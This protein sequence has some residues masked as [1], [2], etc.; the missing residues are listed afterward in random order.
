MLTKHEHRW[1]GLRRSF[2]AAAACLLM[3]AAAPNASAAPLLLPHAVLGAI[4]VTITSHPKAVTDV[5]GAS[6]SWSTTGIVGET[7]CRIDA[8][9]FTYCPGH[10]ARY[11]GLGDGHHTFTIRIRNGYK[12]TAT[13]SFSWLIDTVAPTSPNVIGGSLVWRSPASATVSASGS[14]D[15]LS[16]LAGYHWRSSTDGSAW[17]SVS[18]GATAVIRAQG[19]TYVQFQ[20]V[21]KAGNVSAWQ[22]A[23]NSPTNEVRLDHTPP[24]A[25]TVVGG[26]ALWQ[27]VASETVTGSGSTDARSGVDRYEYRE[28]L[29]GGSSWTAVQAGSSDTVTDE[30]ERLV[31]FRA[32]DAAGNPGPWAP[33]LPGG[34]NTV[35]IDRSGPSSPLVAGGSASWS[36]ATAV[37]V[38]GSG[39]VDAGFGVDHYLHRES[40]DGGV[41]WSSPVTGTSVTIA[42]EGQTLVQF[43]SVDTAGNSSAW[44]PS[45]GSAAGTVRLDRTGPAD[46]TV[47]ITPPGWQSTLAILVFGSGSTDALAG[48]DHYQ[49]RSSADGGSTWSPATDGDTGVVTAEGSTI[50][51]FRAVDGAGNAS[52]W[53]PGAAGVSN[54]V[55]IDRTAPT[56]PT[57]AGGSAS[58][59]ATAS[60]AISASGSTDALGNLDHYEYRRSTDGGI[61]WGVPATGAVDNVTA[62]GETLVQLRAVDAAGNASP[63]VPGS[64]SAG[65][66]RLDRSAPGD[67]VVSGGSLAWQSAASVTVTGSGSSDPGGSGAGS[68]EYR[69]S[70]DN[71][72]SYG[73]AASGASV[74]LN[75]AGNYVVQFRAVDGVGLTSAW[76]PATP[77]FANTA[78]IT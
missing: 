22:P 56:A 78:C 13:A 33:A 57:V 45:P 37:T 46:P 66:V 62:E 40:T 6:F 63:W 55:R 1:R 44:S 11:S 14:S 28:S 4:T 21:D 2:A 74:L 51:Q 20:S 35:R 9:P 65:T 3:V 39:S 41:S 31:Q 71:G 27:G 12:V 24:T 76:A 72:A 70:T 18:A 32:V 67:P 26:S 69:I 64:G 16:G 10:P 49:F 38:T 23:G 8:H 43:Q 15:A 73:A 59:L 19:E 58:W 61:S 77:G 53:A 29:T 54:T 48:V 42:A 68:Y 25:P 36:A 30:G 34:A 60:T 7:R 50:V 5:H 17:S 47:G 52:A 75:L